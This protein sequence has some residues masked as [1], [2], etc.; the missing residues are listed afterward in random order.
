M[1]FFSLFGIIYN[2]TL[3]IYPTS[4]LIPVGVLILVSFLLTFFDPELFGRKSNSIVPV[5]E[6]TEVE[7]VDLN[8]NQTKELQVE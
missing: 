5:V 2:K 4:Y 3:S 8:A 6:V 7:N 1:F